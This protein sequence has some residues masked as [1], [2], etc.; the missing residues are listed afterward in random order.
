MNNK[1][2]G[3][4]GIG[5]VVFLCLSL[6]FN[7]VFLLGSSRRLAGNRLLPARQPHFSEALV[8]AGSDG[9]S[10]KIALIS[11]RGLISSTISGTL[12]ETMVDDIKTA[13]QQATDDDRVKAIVLSID[14]PG[15]E[16]TASDTIYNAV[17]KARERKPVVVYMG[18]VAASGGYYIS[19]GGSYLMASETTITGSIGVI[20]QT[21]NYQNLLGKIGLESVVFKSGKFK[22]MLSG[23]RTLTPEEIAY[24]QGLVMQTYDKFLGIVAAERK[25]PVEELRSGIADGRIISGK[26][27]LADKLINQVGQIEDAYEKAREMGKATG[28]AVIRYEAPFRFGRLLRMFGQSSESKI[29]INLIDRLVPELESGKI[30]LLPGFYAP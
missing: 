22:D 17:R 11:L 13:L 24:I 12:G 14:S 4:L 27:A 1:R 20:I 10:E 7:F 29:Q 30:Y 2:F 19:C 6:F 26:D 8:E 18:S 5:L 3:C 15:G 25:L 16:V 21:L 23:A 28:A 9:V